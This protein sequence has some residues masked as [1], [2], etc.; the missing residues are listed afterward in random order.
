MN[1]YETLSYTLAL[2]KNERH[3]FVQCPVVRVRKDKIIASSN[4]FSFS[5]SIYNTASLLFGLILNV[6]FI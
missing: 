6:N 1:S 3:Y 5:N 4:N 2:K